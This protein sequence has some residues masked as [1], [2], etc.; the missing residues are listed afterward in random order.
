[1][2]FRIKRQVA[3]FDE[4]EHMNELLNRI[5]QPASTTGSRPESDQ[6]QATQPPRK[7]LPGA[8]QSAYDRPWERSIYRGV[9]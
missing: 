8:M 5:Q 2:A 6:H 9:R 3:S 1:M 7:G 4:Q